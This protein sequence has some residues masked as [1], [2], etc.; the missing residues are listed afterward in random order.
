MSSRETRFRAFVQHHHNAIAAKAIACFDE[1]ERGVVVIRVRHL[2]GE[3]EF[4][5]KQG[6][7]PLEYKTLDDYM[8]EGGTSGKFDTEMLN[9]LRRYDPEVQAVVVAQHLD[10]EYDFAVIKAGK[11]MASAAVKSAL[12]DDDDF[13]EDESAL[14]GAAMGGGAAAM[15]DDDEEEEEE[16]EPPK[17]KKDKK[18]KKKKKAEDIPVGEAVEIIPPGK[19]VAK[20][21]KKKKKDKAA[22]AANDL[23]G[24][25]HTIRESPSS[26]SSIRPSLGDSSHR[27]STRSAMNDPGRSAIQASL[28]EARSGRSAIR[29]ALAPEGEIIR[30]RVLMVQFSKD[31][32]RALDAIADAM[33]QPDTSTWA[34]RALLDSARKWGK[35][36]KKK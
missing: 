9:I 21:K 31:E 18:K 4:R 8:D 30:D 7:L 15:L 12:D 1:Y 24:L 36:L 6:S 35:E 23:S 26:R 33:E 34:R 19:K 11:A 14:L 28:R 17:K 20:P 27:S 32:L 29:A 2:E 22:A 3:E 25:V 13:D 5:I 10:G 16:E